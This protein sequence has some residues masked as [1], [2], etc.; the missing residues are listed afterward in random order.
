VIVDYY[1]SASPSPGHIRLERDDV[2]AEIEHNGFHLLAKREHIPKT[3][4]MLTFE[5]TK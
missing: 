3:Q 4:Y 5:K 1:K 2:A